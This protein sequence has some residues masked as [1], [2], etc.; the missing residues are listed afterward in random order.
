MNYQPILFVFLSGVLTGIND[1]LFQAAN[2]LA[3]R[4]WVVDNLIALPEDNEFVKAAVIGCCFMA[5]WFGQ[6]TLEET[7]RVRKILLITLIASVFVIATTKAISKTVFLPRPFIQSQK[8]YHLEADTLVEN[9]HLA[10]RVPLD[11]ASRDNY[12]DLLNGDLQT[13]DLGSFPSDHA[14]FYVT[15]A[16]GIWL[17]SRSVGLIALGW[18][19]LVVL[20]G[21]V[22]TGMHSPLDIAAGSAIGLIEL[23][24][25]QSL[26]RGRF[27]QR[28]DRITNWTVQQTALSSALLFAVIFEMSSTLTHVR[29]LLKMAVEISKHLLGRG[30]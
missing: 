15:I 30:V 27:G 3:G 28:L 6:K 21:R 19:F 23:S 11:K 20:A 2:S 12:R 26:L 8:V 9:H 17:A 22:I 16:A 14:G 7:Q 25:C 18:A 10:Y 5:V 29:P 4:S 13:N 1:Y 24:V